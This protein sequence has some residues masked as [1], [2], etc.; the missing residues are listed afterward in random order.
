MKE[1]NVLFI[2]DIVGETGRRMVKLHLPELKKEN[3]IDLVI[4]NGENLAGGFGI[5][6]EKAEEM[7]NAGVN[8]MTTGNHV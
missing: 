4:A 8:V 6:K 7:F 2:G 1:I 5:T 3:H